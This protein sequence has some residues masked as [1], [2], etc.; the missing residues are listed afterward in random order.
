MID[1]N[2]DIKMAKS[3]TADFET[4]TDKDD[5]RIWAW[6]VCNIDDFKELHP[7]IQKNLL[8]LI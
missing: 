2:Q 6:G 3:F 4:T 7:F 1:L 5:L 8:V